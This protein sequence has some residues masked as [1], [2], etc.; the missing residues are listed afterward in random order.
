MATFIP[1]PLGSS[2]RMWGTH[3]L[4]EIEAIQKNF[5]LLNEY[6]PDGKQIAFRDP[7][8]KQTETD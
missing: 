1:N 3:H 2:P 8:F 6:L 7:D 4:L 5:L